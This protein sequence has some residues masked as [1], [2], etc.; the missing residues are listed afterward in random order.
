MKWLNNRWQ[1]LMESPIGKLL[2]QFIKFGMVGIT[3][4]AVSYAI[5]ALILWLG[6]HYLVASVVSFVISVAWSYLLNNR[7]VFKKS[8]DET[9]VWWKALLKAYVSYGITGLV[10]ANILLYLWIDVLGINQYLAF[11]INLVFTIPV[12]FLLNK[13]WA[14]KTEP[15]HSIE[16][17]VEKE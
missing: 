3:N 5:Y 11:V 12:N 17:S 8:E 16:Q 6:G 2:L 1:R 7:F 14:F 9:R 4:T 13:L 15:R 10:L